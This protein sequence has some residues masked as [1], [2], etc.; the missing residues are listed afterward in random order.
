MNLLLSSEQKSWIARNFYKIS[1]A[2]TDANKKR[3]FKGIADKCLSEKLKTTIT[4]AE[5]KVVLKATEVGLNALRAA[6]DK[7]N[8]EP[9][10]YV[11]YLKAI[12]SKREILN[13]LSEKIQRGLK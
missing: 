2:S 6:E 4:V 9:E 7:Y 3:I 11:D 10:K 8:K 13:S 1:S 12:P 5:A